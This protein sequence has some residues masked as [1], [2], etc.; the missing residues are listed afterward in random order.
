MTHMTLQ[1][2]R[3]LIANDSY[4]ITFQSLGQ[5]RGALLRHF[6][7][8]VE[9][10]SPEWGCVRTVGDMVRNL[11]TLDQTDPIHSA[12][13]VDLD[14]KRRC[15][16]SHISI[17]RERVIDGKW[18]DQTRKDVPYAIVVWAKPDERAEYE[19]REQ[20]AK[21]ILS[22][23]TPG[24]IDKLPIERVTSNAAIMRAAEIVR[25]QVAPTDP[26][27]QQPAAPGAQKWAAEEIADACVRAGL[28]ILECNGL[29]EALK[30]SAPG[31]PEAP[32]RLSGAEIFDIA[33]PYFA[34]NAPS[35]HKATQ[36][37][38]VMTS[39]LGFAE[40][41]LDAKRAAQLDGGHGEGEKS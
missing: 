39:L 36:G 20:L 30:G 26:A 37:T 24:R 1:A 11:L 15:R 5:Y 12:F 13:F 14:G 2:V 31:T 6:D 7:S 21:A 32:A 22:D 4:A 3:Q 41:L 27:A 33:A 18:V 40:A 8:L 34:W 17:S 29:I 10:P 28:G 9:A 19:L 23:L 16:T 38:I 35:W 25:G